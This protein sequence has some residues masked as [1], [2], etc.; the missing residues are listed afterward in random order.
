MDV[1][2]AAALLGLKPGTLYSWA[3]KRKV[4]FRKV[5]AALRFHRGDLLEW[6]R[7][8]GQIGEL[9]AAQTSKL[10]MVK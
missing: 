5:G 4:P 9:N 3:S 6:T 2:E 10:R 7:V 8:Q 1:G